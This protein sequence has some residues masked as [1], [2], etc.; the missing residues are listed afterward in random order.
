MM[1]MMIIIIII[2]III[3]VKNDFKILSFVATCLPVSSLGLLYCYGNGTLIIFSK[4][5]LVVYY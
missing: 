5:Q 2:I 3:V 1:M 4:I